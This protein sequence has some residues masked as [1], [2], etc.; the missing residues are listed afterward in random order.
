MA[1]MRVRRWHSARMV[2]WLHLAGVIRT[3]FDPY[4]LAPLADGRATAFAAAAAGRPWPGLPPGV[5]PGAAGP[6]G[7]E[8]RPGV[9]LHDGASS[10]PTAALEADAA[11]ARIEIRRMWFAQHAGLAMGALPLGFGLPKRRW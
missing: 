9:Y 7:A 4:V 1:Q 6:A 8:A 3:A 5:V 11:A 2:I 10:S